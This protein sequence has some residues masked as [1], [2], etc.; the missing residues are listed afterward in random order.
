MDIAV[1]R[2]VLKSKTEGRKTP[3][4][5]IIEALGAQDRRKPEREDRPGPSPLAMPEPAPKRYPHDATSLAEIQRARQASGAPAIGASAGA[6]WH[7]GATDGPTDR[8][9]PRR[10]GRWQRGGILSHLQGA[11]RGYPPRC[12]SFRAATKGDT[13]NGTHYGR[14]AGGHRG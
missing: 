6:L 1:E 13:Q 4:A 5:D 2:K 7:A 14:Q 8:P 10:D 9:A 11:P 12:S 3:K